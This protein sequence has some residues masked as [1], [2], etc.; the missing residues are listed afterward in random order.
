MVEAWQ[1]QH[2]RGLSM[3]SYYRVLRAEHKDRRKLPPSSSNSAA[4]ANQL[5]E[6]EH[7]LAMMVSIVGVDLRI[8]PLL[9]TVAVYLIEVVKCIPAHNAPMRWQIARRYSQFYELDMHLRYIFPQERLPRFPRKFFLMSSTNAAVIKDRLGQLHQ[10]LNELSNIPFVLTCELFNKWLEREHDPPLFTLSCPDHAGFLRK[11]GHLVR[12][13]KNRYFVLKDT[14]LAYFHDDKYAVTLERPIGI[15][16]LVNA[17]VRHVPERSPFCFE[18]TSQQLAP[19]YMEA[20][21]ADD[22]RGWVTA[23]QGSLRWISRLASG[24][25]AAVCR[26]VNPTCKLCTTPD[27]VA[28]NTGDATT[29]SQN[30]KLGENIG[31]FH[32]DLNEKLTQAKEE[33]DANIHSFLQEMQ[34]RTDEQTP[35]DVALTEIASRLLATPVEG[36]FVKGICPSV[37]KSIQELAMVEPQNAA[38]SRLLFVFSPICCVVDT[39]LQYHKAFSKRSRSFYLP[40]TSTKTSLETAW[41]ELDRMQEQAEPTTA[42]AAAAAAHP[43]RPRTY[44]PAPS[45]RACARTPPP[46]RAAFSPVLQPSRPAVQPPAAVPVPSKSVPLPSPTLAHSPVSAPPTPTATAATPPAMPPLCIGSIDKAHRPLS[47]GSTSPRSSKRTLCRICEEE[48]VQAQLKLH[49]QYCVIA[50]ECDDKTFSCDNRMFKLLEALQSCT[51][52]EE[53]PHPGVSRERLIGLAENAAYLPC[54]SPESLNQCF[55]LLQQMQSLLEGDPVDMCTLTFG[56]RMCKVTEEKWA[57]M[58]QYQSLSQEKR[59]GFNVWG[60]LSF[61]CSS[62]ASHAQDGVLS[63]DRDVCMDDFDFIKKISSGGFGSVFLAKKKTTGDKFAVKV[64]KKSDMLRKNMVDGVMAERTILSTVNFPLVVKLYYAFQSEQHL[65]LVME[66]CIGGDV[67]SYL[68][69][70][71]FMEEHMAKVY[72]AEITLALEYLHNLKYVHRDLKPENILINSQ[73]HLRLTDFGLSR[74]GVIPEKRNSDATEDTVIVSPKS[75]PG[76]QSSPRPRSRVLGSPDYLAPEILL[77][78]GHGAAADWWAVGVMLYEFLCGV[79]PFNAASPELIF[80]RILTHDL[81]WPPATYEI[82]I[83]DAARDLITKLLTTDPAKRLGSHGSEEVKQ[84]PF[85]ADINWSTLLHESRT[86]VF[87]PTPDSDE[88]T[89]YFVDH[90]PGSINLGATSPPVAAD[91]AFCFRGFN[92]VSKKNLLEANELLAEQEEPEGQL[93]AGPP[94]ASPLSDTTPVIAYSETPPQL[95]AETQDQPQEDLPDDV[96]QLLSPPQ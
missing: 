34:D 19:Y 21:D 68:S 49:N 4:K 30:G 81:Q 14:V 88:D 32:V 84:H 18:V 75:P 58:H 87:V 66:Y 10:Y 61:T 57:A 38:T 37:V 50:A 90:N 46:A 52:K 92:F 76:G 20:K 16:S 56:R 45:Q 29:S 17:H 15:I 36:L 33:L 91:S 74:I 5:P 1:R 69:N 3:D 78:T 65:F 12:N 48:Y 39:C 82:T 27:V 43:P 73:G 62:L 94:P 6:S 47:E 67:A 7:P 25:A 89:T 83:S 95:D 31:S 28:A 86:D 26:T 96:L 8:D 93:H 72:I 9:E 11:E 77:G 55:Q 13:W 60:L 63:G 59:K 70:V 80:R 85:F 40:A 44:Q 23:I 2:R 71:G 79:P 64:L 24:R 51:A 35:V 53:K 22:L 54:D 41:Q 42:A